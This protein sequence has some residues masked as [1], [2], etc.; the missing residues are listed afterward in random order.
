MRITALLKRVADLMLEEDRI[1]DVGWKYHSVY[2]APFRLTVDQG[3][4]V[5]LL[6][7]AGRLAEAWAL[8]DSYLEVNQGRRY[9]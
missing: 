3:R 1:T 4:D 7:A 2:Q 5:S 6:Y 9:W 8:V